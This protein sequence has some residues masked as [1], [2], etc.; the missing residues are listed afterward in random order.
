MTNKTKYLIYRYLIP[1]LIFLVIWMILEFFYPE[2][3]IGK[4]GFI[5]GIITYLLSPKTKKINFLRGQNIQIKWF[6]LG[7]IILLPMND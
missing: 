6:I 5:V 7:K 2:M 1:L 3:I 4:K